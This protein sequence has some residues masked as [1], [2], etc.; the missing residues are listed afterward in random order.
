MD[1]TEVNERLALLYEAELRRCMGTLDNVP[2]SAH[3]GPAHPMLIHVPE[4]YLE[5]KMRV[6]VFGQET[7]GWEDTLSDKKDVTFLQGVYR[8][9]LE[10]GLRHRGPYLNAVKS[11]QRLLSGLEPSCQIVLNNV[12]KIGKAWNK[13]RPPDSVIEWQNRW[14]THVIKEELELLKPHLVIFLCGPNYDPFIK[15]VFPQEVTFQPLNTR[16]VRQL[17]R[18][19]SPGHLPVNA[20]RTYHPN[21]G[22]RHGFTKIQAEIMSEVCGSAA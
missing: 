14:F 3:G 9:F 18:V 8:G 7:N 2:D 12:I 15:R 10:K 11:F 4:G 5:S 17:A 13:G 1:D 6:M 19:V 21:Y 16:D 22:Y 20:F